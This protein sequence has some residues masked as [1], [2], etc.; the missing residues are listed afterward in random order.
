MSIGPVL[1]GDIEEEL[2]GGIQQYCLDKWKKNIANGTN[3]W[4]YREDGLVSTYYT[5][6]KTLVIQGNKEKEEQ[7]EGIL[8]GKKS[9]K[10]QN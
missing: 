5:G 2:R 3:L 1:L 4:T 8:E 7:L 9:P 6:R 10:C